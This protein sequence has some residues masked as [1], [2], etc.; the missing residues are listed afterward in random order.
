[1]NLWVHLQL[2]EK[3]IE[4]KLLHPASTLES[5]IQVRIT[6]RNKSLQTQCPNKNQSQGSEIVYR[7]VIDHQCITSKTGADISHANESTNNNG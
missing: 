4:I 6:F 3:Q 5:R 7:Y 1:M 2:L